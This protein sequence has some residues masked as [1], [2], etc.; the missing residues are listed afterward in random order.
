[1][2]KKERVNSRDFLRLAVITAGQQ[3]RTAVQVKEM[4]LIYSCEVTEEE[5]E[6]RVVLAAAFP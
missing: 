3:L 2:Q 6:E 5:E 1:M 4:S